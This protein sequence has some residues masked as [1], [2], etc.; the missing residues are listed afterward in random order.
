MILEIEAINDSKTEQTLDIILTHELV[1]I[2]L[3][4]KSMNMKFIIDLHGIQKKL[5]YQTS[6]YN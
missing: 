3:Q 4:G 2:I 6:L 1:L 5:A